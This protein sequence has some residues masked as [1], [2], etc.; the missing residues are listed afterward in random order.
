MPVVASKKNVVCL[1]WVLFEDK[2]KV[3]VGLKKRLITLLDKVETGKRY[4]RRRRK[5]FEL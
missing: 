1:M 2:H 3:C 4:K 5:G